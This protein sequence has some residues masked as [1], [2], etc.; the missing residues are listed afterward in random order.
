MQP[1][2]HPIHRILFIDDDEDDFLLFKESVKGID[3]SI[4]VALLE[5]YDQDPSKF[6]WLDP[7]LIFLDLNM[8]RCNGFECLKKLK[9]SDLKD[10]P[11]VIFTTSRNQQH[12][13]KAYQQGATLYLSKPFTFTDL[14]KAIR[15]VLNL[16]W[17][18]PEAITSSFC[19]NGRYKAFPVG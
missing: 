15:G 5:H 2:N 7:D 17:D 13:D 16:D 12:I 1:L 10:V 9:N 11:V 3:P 19:S 14:N 8:P 4:T 18:H 6:P